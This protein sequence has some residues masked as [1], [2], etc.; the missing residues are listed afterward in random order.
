MRFFLAGLFCGLVFIACGGSKIRRDYDDFPIRLKEYS[1]WMKCTDGDYSSACKYECTKYDR[2]NEC[3]K[4]HERIIKMNI[5]K[6]LDDGYLL[7][8]RQFLLKLLISEK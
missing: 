6:A 4:D 5:N 7:I 3:K 2:K 8:S 1:L